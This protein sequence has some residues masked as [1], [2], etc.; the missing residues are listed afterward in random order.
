MKE[1]P[2]GAVCPSVWC[3]GRCMPRADSGSWGLPSWG[4]LAK[5]TIT[6]HAMWGKARH[7][8]NL[9]ETYWNKFY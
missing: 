4:R 5:W 7:G 8:Y 1:Y 9:V 3:E 2:R 6:R